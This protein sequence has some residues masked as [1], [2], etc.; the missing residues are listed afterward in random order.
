[1]VLAFSRWPF[2]ISPY[3]PGIILIK[4]DGYS[5]LHNQTEYDQKPLILAQNKRKISAQNKR[6]CLIFSIERSIRI[7]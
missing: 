2:S 4:F 3:L 5:K 6:K 1:M 7:N